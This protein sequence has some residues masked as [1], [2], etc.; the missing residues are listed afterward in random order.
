MRI[1]T[2]SGVVLLVIVSILSLITSATIVRAADAD[3]DGVND[4]I[5]F[6]ANTAGPAGPDGCADAQ[7]WEMVQLADCNGP[8]M[9]ISGAM[10]T[11]DTDVAI[12]FVKMSTPTVGN[13]NV[14][15][16]NSPK[17]VV[18]TTLGTQGRIYGK[19]ASSPSGGK[20]IVSQN[21]SAN[22]GMR[23]RTE[24]IEA[25]VYSALKD[26]QP[27]GPPTAVAA[28]EQ[29]IFGVHL[30]AKADLTHTVSIAHQDKSLSGGTDKFTS[31]SVLAKPNS[32]LTLSAD[33]KNVQNDGP[34]PFMT[35]AAAY[36]QS[37]TLAA[38]VS[39]FD[40]AA[41]E[42]TIRVP[43]LGDYTGAV[44][45]MEPGHVVSITPHLSAGSEVKVVNK[46]G[47]ASA[48]AAK[49]LQV[50]LLK[51]TATGLKPVKVAGFGTSSAISVK[52]SNSSKLTLALM[53]LPLSHGVIGNFAG[54]LSVT[55][56]GANAKNTDATVTTLE[57]GEIFG[58]AYDFLVSTGSCSWAGLGTLGEATHAT[59]QLL[60]GAQIVHEDDPDPDALPLS[61][62]V[63]KP[64]FLVASHGSV[65]NGTSVQLAV[66]ATDEKI[67]SRSGSPN[68][69][70]STF[71]LSAS[72]GV[73]LTT[74]EG[75]HNMG[76]VAAM[77]PVLVHHAYSASV[78]AGPMTVERAGN[79]L[80]VTNNDSTGN[81]VS[82][83][84]LLEPGKS[85]AVAGN[86]SA[87]ELETATE[88]LA[89]EA[90]EWI[91]IGSSAVAQPSGG[92]VALTSRSPLNLVDAAAIVQ[93]GS[94]IHVRKGSL[95]L[96]VDAA[97]P[98]QHEFKVALGV[99]PADDLKVRVKP[100][101]EVEMLAVD[102]GAAES[103]TLKASVT[104]TFNVE[105]YSGTTLVKTV[106][107][108][109]TE[110]ALPDADGDGV[111]GADDHCPDQQGD[112][113][114]N[115]CLFTAEATVTLKTIN[116]SVPGG[117]T[118]TAPIAGAEA[119]LF[120]RNDSAFQSTYGTKNPSHAIYDQVFNNN[121]GTVG[122]C[123]SE[124]SGLC[125]AGNETDG[126][127][128]MIV[129]YADTS[130]KTAYIG[131]PISTGDYVNGTAEKEMAVI[132]TILKDGSIKLSAGK[133]SVVTG[134]M[135][136]IVSP[137]YMNWESTTEYYPFVF[138]SDSDWTVDLCLEVPE[139]YQ[140]VE[141]EDCVKTLVAGETVAVLFTV[142]E[143][144]S[145]KPDTTAKFKLKGPDGKVKSLDINIPGE[146]KSKKKK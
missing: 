142:Q 62:P 71:A 103:L 78:P 137:A 32:F 39:D 94:K 41:K 1:T 42:A 5:D 133:T 135:L 85:Y 79:G 30:L 13:F 36:V 15:F 33:G 106:A 102:R 144:G 77:D 45:K 121:V 2:I 50:V 136:E 124:S 111:A 27:F 55:T 56:D 73:R 58:C 125:K 61:V 139:G 57:Q 17:T 88:P 82:T 101:D 128:L 63:G 53:H 89:I 115:G 9:T 7:G 31:V 126:D 34:E 138:T 112:L 51:G 74:H 140:I 109:A 108:G 70:V 68:A 37:E 114:K 69:V 14:A 127:H 117:G 48:A 141:G 49:P 90:L 75:G 26:G 143:V 131:S 86:G 47:G 129:K 43:A 99:S 93:P 110:M 54:H 145:P 21:A 60:P 83:F 118:T 123:V 107:P 122:S 96:K 18:R 146:K 104:N 116:Q 119:R 12:L 44:V 72:H 52:A 4:A 130:G 3:A 65:K 23:I 87:L 28:Q 95:V 91:L 29:P 66:H 97:S 19:P 64:T 113:D 10:C 40:D 100:G 80:Q 132:K 25:T 76:L 46:T 84:S 6:C 38:A 35:Y 22:Q 120:D 134:S 67:E 8:G 20:V 81:T 105:V 59:A 11:I 98:V 16:T 92:E 24:D